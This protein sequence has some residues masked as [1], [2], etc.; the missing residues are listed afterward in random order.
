MTKQY[1]QPFAE[2]TLNCERFR[3]PA[4][5]TLADGSVLAGADVRYGH[6]SDS[7]NN[8][9]I[10]L[11]QDEIVLFGLFGQVHTKQIFPLIEDYGFVG[12]E[13]LGLGIVQHT[14]AK[15]NHIAPHINDG[16][17]QAVAETVVDS[18]VLLTNQVCVL[19]FLVGIALF[20]HSIHQCIPGIGR[21]A[22]SKLGD[23]A[24]A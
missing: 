8:I 6:G 23:D 4:L 19:Q 14:A 20:P 24:L 5:Y 7:P 9:D 11:D 3:I 1:T 2:G 15:A 12:V 21:K 13:I 22:N 16:E 10:A 17:H 18:A